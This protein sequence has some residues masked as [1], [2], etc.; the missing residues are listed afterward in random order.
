MKGS[1]ARG[2]GIDGMVRAIRGWFRREPDRP[3]EDEYVDREYIEGE[4]PKKIGKL[5]RMAD[6]PD[7]SER[8]LRPDERKG[9]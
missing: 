6:I 1:G 2:G 5:D 4:T 3:P 7:K 9:A 8:H